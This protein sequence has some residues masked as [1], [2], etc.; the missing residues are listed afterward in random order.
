MLHAD[1]EQFHQPHL[2]AST[3]KCIAIGAMIFGVVQF[4]VVSA[5]ATFV[6]AGAKEPGQ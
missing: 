4:A 2:A 1:N 5:G 6:H 3:G